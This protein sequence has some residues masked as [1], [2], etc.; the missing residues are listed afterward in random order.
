MDERDKSTY[1]TYM[2]RVDGFVIRLEGEYGISE[3]CGNEIFSFL[4]FTLDNALM[5]QRANILYLERKD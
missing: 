5:M 2:E 4:Q 3:E 1:S